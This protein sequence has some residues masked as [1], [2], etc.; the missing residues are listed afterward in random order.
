LAARPL[1]DGAN[2]RQLWAYNTLTTI[3]CLSRM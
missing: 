2:H 3:N 1:K